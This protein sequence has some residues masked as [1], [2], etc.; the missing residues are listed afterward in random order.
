MAE[1]E[2]IWAIGT[3]SGTSL[4]GV[5]WATV[6]TDGVDVFEFGASGYRPYTT[7]ERDILRAALGTWPDQGSNAQAQA[8]QTVLNAHIEALS[9]VEGDVIGFHGQT[10]NHDPASRRTFQIGDGDSL[11]QALGRPVVWD[12]RSADVAAGGQGAPLAPFY[13]H[14]LARRRALGDNSFFLNLGG[15]GNV[16]FIRDRSADPEAHGN[17]I[18]FDTGP[19]NAPINDLMKSHFDLEYD[20]NGQVAAQGTVDIERVTTFLD[21][22]YFKKLPPKSLDRDEFSDLPILLEL[23]SPEDAVA[24]ATAIAVNSV[25]KSLDL[26]PVH[27]QGVVVCGGG[28]LNATIMTQL[29]ETSFNCATAEA[30]GFDGDMIEAQAFAYLAVRS[31]RGMTISA[32]GTTGAPEPMTGGRISYLK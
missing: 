13:H 31:M 25:I 21:H 10:L 20:K 2:P 11:S 28:R 9:D 18:A 23:L 15:V 14:A 3:M 30:Y 22:P 8:H 4:D 29:E 5:D 1:F 26:I 27:P 32:P 19:A 12:F 7:D 17:L 16:T 24:T 6:L